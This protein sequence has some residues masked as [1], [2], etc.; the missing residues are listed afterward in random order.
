MT[1]PMSSGFSN[2]TVLLLNLPELTESRESKMAMDKP[3]VCLTQ[4]YTSQQCDLNG[5]PMF[6]GYCVVI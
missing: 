3:D 2:S 4:V 6:S 5:Y 1:I